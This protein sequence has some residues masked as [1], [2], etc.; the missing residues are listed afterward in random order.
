MLAHHRSTLH[1]RLATSLGPQRVGLA[2]LQLQPPSLDDALAS[3]VADGCTEVTL[4]PLFLGGGDHVR[5]DLPDAVRRAGGLRV[6]VLP[7]LLEN[8]GVAAAVETLARGA[9]LTP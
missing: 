2:F 5:R 1:E 9:I 4:L 8:D 6:S 7:A 3:A